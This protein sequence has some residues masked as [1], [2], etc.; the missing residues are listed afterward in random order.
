MP[1]PETGYA[2][3]VTIDTVV[4]SIYANQTK[5]FQKS[6]TSA[7]NATWVT[8][9]TVTGAVMIESVVVR[10]NGATTAD[11]TS[12]TVNGGTSDVVTFIDAVTGVKANIDAADKQVSW[13][14]AVNIPTTKTIRMNLTGTG[15]TAVDL[16]V[17]IKYLSISSG[18]LA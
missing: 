15:A 2:A 18:S 9:A 1:I 13:T 8:V 12:I 3:L 4:D 11:L 17:T 5:F 6:I 16:Q 10:S 14:G 7:A